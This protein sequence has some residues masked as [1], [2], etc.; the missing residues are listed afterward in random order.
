MPG[1][2]GSLLRRISAN[3]RQFLFSGFVDGLGVV[4]LTA[5][6][7]LLSAGTDAT[8]SLVSTTGPAPAGQTDIYLS[9]VDLSQDAGASMTC[10]E[11][12]ASFFL[13]PRQVQTL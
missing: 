12:G 1:C 3:G 6:E 5:D 13:R 11:N 7:A 4:A 9:R 10:V 2:S 8:A